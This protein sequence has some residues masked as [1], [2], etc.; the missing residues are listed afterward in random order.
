M[1][2]EL[3][4]GITESRGQVTSIPDFIASNHKYY[5]N[6]KAGDKGIV[7]MYVKGSGDNIKEFNAIWMTDKD[8]K[9]ITDK[10]QEEMY[11]NK[12]Y[13]YKR[14]QIGVKKLKTGWKTTKDTNSKIVKPNTKLSDQDVINILKN[15]PI[16]G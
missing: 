3:F 11:Q 13:S 10:Q 16:E 9:P 7:T 5:V 12:D 14:Q 4:T 2:K 8:G 1:F 6:G 15:L